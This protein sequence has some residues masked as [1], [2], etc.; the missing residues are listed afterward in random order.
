ML[1]PGGTWDPFSISLMV[2]TK[3]LDLNAP[4]QR[5]I[6]ESR[7]GR[8]E[9]RLPIYALD[10]RLRIPIAAVAFFSGDNINF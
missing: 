10:A 5:L 3:A 2:F 6:T 8:L 4:V 9:R 7:E 1:D